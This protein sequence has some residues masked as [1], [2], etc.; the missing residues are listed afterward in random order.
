MKAGKKQAMPVM[1]RASD[2]Y[3]QA[4]LGLRSSNAAGKHS[5]KRDKRAR[6]RSA[7]LRRTL[8][9]W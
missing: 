2:E 7:Q 6:T 1:V 9:D 4:I 3:V 8:K 5:D